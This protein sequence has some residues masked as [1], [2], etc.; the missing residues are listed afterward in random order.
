MDM[1]MWNSLP[2]S[3]TVINAYVV[4]IRSKLY[5]K[6]AFCFSQ[7]SKEARFFLLGSIEK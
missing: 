1:K 3:G 7:C 6:V 4:T 2:S 5:L